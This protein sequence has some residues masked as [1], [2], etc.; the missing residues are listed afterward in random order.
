MYGILFSAVTLVAY[1]EL[2]NM[3]RWGVFLL[4][5]AWSMNILILAVMDSDSSFLDQ[6]RFWVCVILL[7][8]SLAVILPHWSSFKTPQPAGVD[9]SDQE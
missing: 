3:R 8:A 9:D 1:Y 4:A 2:W 6:F 7:T 5:A